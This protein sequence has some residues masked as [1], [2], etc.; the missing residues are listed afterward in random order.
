MTDTTAIA[1]PRNASNS[2]SESVIRIRGLR[3]QFGKQVIHDNLDLDVAKGEVLGV[4]GGS[5]TGKSVLLRTIVGLQ[6]PAAGNIELL[7]EDVL[8]LSDDAK[9]ALRTRTGV[10]FQDGALFSSLTVA[11]NIQVPMREHT[12]LT[13]RLMDELAELK[14]AMVGLPPDAAGKYPSELSGG[15]RKRAGLARALSLDPE[16]VFLDEPTA[17]L[18]PIGAAAFDQLILSL[19]KSLGLTVFMV[20]HDLD[21]LAAICDRI[22]ALIDKK[23][24]VATMAEH[25]R[26][27]DPWLHEYFHGPRARA[28]LDAKASRVSA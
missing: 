6:R 16:I 13:Q 25:M 3:T 7:G 9:E 15:M 2:L 8:A 4:V 19:Q 28:A 27:D 18:D 5:G 26:D 1:A 22:A 24:R 10:L 20:T 17:G 23:V 14:I 21:S 11:E 12:D